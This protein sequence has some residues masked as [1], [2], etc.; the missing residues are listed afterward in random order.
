MAPH[1]LCTFITGS[2][3]V[4]IVSR[5]LARLTYRYY[6]CQILCEIYLAELTGVASYTPTAPTPPHNLLVHHVLTLQLGH[7]AFPF[8]HFRFAKV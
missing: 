2:S 8:C 6:P 1:Y 4:G 3:G 5:L 7:V